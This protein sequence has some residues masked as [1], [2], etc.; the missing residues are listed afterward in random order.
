MNTI[1]SIFEALYV[2]I[3]PGWALSYFFYHQKTI[4]VLNRTALSFALSII[5][6]P[7]LAFFL[8]L[9][10]LKVTRLTVGIEAMIII[11]VSS[12]ILARK[13]AWKDER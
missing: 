12:V 3:L 1:I 6:L 10:S 13:K 8:N 4:S 2:L 11:L 5:A 9:L 7:L